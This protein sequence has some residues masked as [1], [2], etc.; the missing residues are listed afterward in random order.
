[1]TAIIEAGDTL[2]AAL[3]KINREIRSRRSYGVRIE[4]LPTTRKAN[5]IAW[6][7]GS[8]SWYV[9][10]PDKEIRCKSPSSEIQQMVNVC[11]HIENLS[12]EEARVLL[13]AIQRTER[14]PEG[15][16]WDVCWKLMDKVKTGEA[17]CKWVPSKRQKLDANEIAV[18]G[19]NRS[20]LDILTR[21]MEDL[22]LYSGSFE[23]K[24]R[25]VYSLRGIEVPP[26]MKN[27][28]LDQLSPIDI[29]AFVDKVTG[30]LEEQEG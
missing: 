11:N 15:A 28:P 10:N 5:R 29:K 6:S 16:A 19:L 26:A 2:D 18:V 22:P 1:M 30:Y 23:A 21:M 24:Q 3:D 25:N 12:R 7:N 9:Q 20:T 17:D 4:N 14:D 27:I 13:E 8:A